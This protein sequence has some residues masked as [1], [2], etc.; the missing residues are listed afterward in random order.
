MAELTK[1]AW[2][3]KAVE[4]AMVAVDA[5]WNGYPVSRGMIRDSDAEIML[6]AALP[7]ITAK[8]RADE[9]AHATALL[10]KYRT[11]LRAAGL[12]EAVEVVD[13][14]IRVINIGA[15]EGS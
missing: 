10:T 2:M 12:H 5:S 4:A 15:K 11:R 9:R 7:S 8:A 13:S 14:C 3:A 6:A 1:P